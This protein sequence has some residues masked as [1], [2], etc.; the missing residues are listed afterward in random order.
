MKV[1]YTSILFLFLTHSV[2]SQFGGT[3]FFDGTLNDWTNEDDTITGLTVLPNNDGNNTKFL[4]KI[5]DGSNTGAGRL[6]IKNAVRFSGDYT[7]NNQGEIDCLGTIN[8]ILKNLNA[9]NLNMRLVLSGSDGT[10]LVSTNAVI[11]SPSNEYNFIEFNL[12]DPDF[13][14]VS[15]SGS[16]ESVYQ[17]VT[18]ISIIHN[19]NITAEGETIEGVFEIDAIEIIQ[20]LDTPDLKKSSFEIYPNPTKDLLT[21]ESDILSNKTFTVFDV[22]GKNILSFKSKNSLVNFDMSKLNSG[23]Y[24]LKIEVDGKFTTKKFIKI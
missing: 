7:C 23:V 14:V 16:V 24:F 21:V 10:T 4:Q 9:Y 2:L 1:I 3:N 5:S 6:S 22:L 8:L 11:V 19:S 15:G 18:S 17:N 13:T 12:L 20:L